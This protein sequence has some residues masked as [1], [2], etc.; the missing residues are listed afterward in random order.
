MSLQSIERQVFIQQGQINVIQYRLDALETDV[1]GLP[2]LT[3]QV[4]TNTADIT[5]L[6]GLILPIWKIGGQHNNPNTQLLASTNTLIRTETITTTT[7]TAKYL[8]LAS[9]EGT[10]SANG[11]IYMTI[12]R[13]TNASP[14]ATT[15]INLTDRVSALTNSI[16]GNGLSMWCSQYNT[17]NSSAYASVVD[18][19]NFIGN[20]QYSIWALDTAPIT[21]TGSELA[22]LTIIQVLP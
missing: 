21:N 7:T 6:Q 1:A 12:G 3:T 22:N 11:T 4:A 17:A 20:V 13:S 15:T 14:S 19:P 5:T 2:D 16:S 8:I 10:S 18:T 9:F